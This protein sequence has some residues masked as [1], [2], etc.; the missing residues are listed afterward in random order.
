MEFRILRH[1]SRVAIAISPESRSNLEGIHS[2]VRNAAHRRSLRRPD[3]IDMI[4][5][6][7]STPQESVKEVV[8]I[9]VLL[10]HSLFGDGIPR[11]LLQRVSLAKPT[12]A[13]LR[14]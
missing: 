13:L 11:R 5:T 8:G 10:T 2:G 4:R 14:L 7:V 12:S 9:R 6:K 3:S 1:V